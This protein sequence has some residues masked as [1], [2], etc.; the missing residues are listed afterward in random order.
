[1]IKPACRW[2]SYTQ[3]TSIIRHYFNRIAGSEVITHNNRCTLLFSSCRITKSLIKGYLQSSNTRS[4]FYRLSWHPL[5]RATHYYTA[6]ES[7]LRFKRS[8]FSRFTRESSSVTI[9]RGRI[10][11]NIKILYIRPIL[12]NKGLKRVDNSKSCCLRSSR[13]DL[14]TS[15]GG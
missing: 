13:F 9:I 10:I 7:V 11:F 5:C 12:C 6:S 2:H 4:I 15:S 3:L 8:R 14:N 1:M